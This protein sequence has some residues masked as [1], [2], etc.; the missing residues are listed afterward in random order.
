MGL[1]MIRE[2]LSHS[3]DYIPDAHKYWR[4]LRV[5]DLSDARMVLNLIPEPLSHN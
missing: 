4:S 1:R 5:D 2:P 3:C